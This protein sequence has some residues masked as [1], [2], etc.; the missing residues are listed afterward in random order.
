MRGI[1]ALIVL[2]GHTG[3]YWH[4][5]LFRGY[6]AVDLFFILSGFVIAHAYGDA[7]ANGTMP[8]S[9]FVKVRLIRLYPIFLLSVLAAAADPIRSHIH[10]HRHTADIPQLV[11]LGWSIALTALYLPSKLLGSPYLF[12]LNAVYWSLSF[13]LL[14]NFLYGATQSVLRKNA[15]R[16]AVV[17]LGA[18]VMYV[19]YE[20]GN[21]NAGWTWTGLSLAAGILRSLFGVF[22]GVFLFGIREK[23]AAQISK[24]YGWLALLLVALILVSPSAGRLDWIIDSIAVV[25]CFPIAVLWLAHSRAQHGTSVLLALGSA[26]YATYVLHAPIGKTLGGELG[27]IVDRFAP[28]SGIVLVALLIALSLALEKYFDIPVRK[29]LSKWVFGPVPMG[30]LRSLPAQPASAGQ[31]RPS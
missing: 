12:P 21:L 1:A 24:D 25:V 4:F 30:A 31:S 6:L 13:E 10:I 28:V 15:L 14:A 5:G 23:V 19:A 18:M 16:A 11:S 29:M 20:G 9:S 2:T 27:G 3:S 22:C 26:S 8:F 17:L 7:L